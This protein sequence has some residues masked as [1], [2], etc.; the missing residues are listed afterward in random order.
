LTIESNT[1]VTFEYVIEWTK[2]HPDI[3]IGP[4]KGDIVGNSQV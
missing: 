1:P 2:P 3:K 4:L